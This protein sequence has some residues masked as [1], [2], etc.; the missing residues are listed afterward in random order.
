LK[1][2]IKDIDRQA[3]MDHDFNQLIQGGVAGV[4]NQYRDKL[5]PGQESPGKG[6]M[7]K[8]IRGAVTRDY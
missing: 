2:K 5:P 8:L 1:N 7:R 6:N 4:N 3:V